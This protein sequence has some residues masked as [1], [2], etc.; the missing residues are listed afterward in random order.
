MQR[1]AQLE[2]DR[3]NRE[4]QQQQQQ[5]A[6]VEEGKECLLAVGDLIGGGRWPAWLDSMVGAGE[7]W[8]FLSRATQHRMTGEQLAR[9]YGAI[10]QQRLQQE[11]PQTQ[12]KRHAAQDEEQQEQQ[13]PRGATSAA[14]GGCACACAECSVPMVECV[15]H[16]HTFQI[17]VPAV[18]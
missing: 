5:K 6:A 3:G 17:C 4:Q 8:E 7:L 9:L 13:A 1:L 12:H 10:S 16:P 15:P 14:G 18:T 2:A 11:V